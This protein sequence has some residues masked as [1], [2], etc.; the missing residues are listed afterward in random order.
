MV[1]WYC[2]SLYLLLR[3]PLSLLLHPSS[4]VRCLV[5]LGVHKCSTKASSQLGQFC[6]TAMKSTQRS[7]SRQLLLKAIMCLHWSPCKWVFGL[8][9]YEKLIQIVKAAVTRLLLSYSQPDLMLPAQFSCLEPAPEY[10]NI[11]EFHFYTSCLTKRTK[12][13]LPTAVAQTSL[14]SVTS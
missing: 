8:G 14:A 5:K 3:N 13:L 2:L 6:K 11:V 9:I 12:L 4:E 1:L 10:V 7:H